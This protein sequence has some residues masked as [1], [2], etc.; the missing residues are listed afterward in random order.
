MFLRF[1]QLHALCAYS[2]VVL[3]CGSVESA[4]PIDEPASRESL[5]HDIELPLETRVV[6]A[7]V[8][9][10]STLASLFDDHSLADETVELV[11][12]VSEVFDPRRLRVGYLYRMLFGRDKGELR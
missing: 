12:A 9:R 3:A 1:I 7:A 4:T 10:G 6:E 5:T 2:L 11:D 8:P